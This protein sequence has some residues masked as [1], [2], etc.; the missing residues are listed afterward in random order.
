M[1]SASLRSGLSNIDLEGRGVFSVIW[2]GYRYTLVLI[3]VFH[4]FCRELIATRS[5]NLVSSRMGVLFHGRG[6]ACSWSR[7]RLDCLE[8]WDSIACD[9]L[10]LGSCKS[11]FNNINWVSTGS[12]PFPVRPRSPHGWMNPQY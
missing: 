5:V 11:V 8:R 6:N 7:D 2:T 3:I 1:F 4:G 12:S 10:L 9:L